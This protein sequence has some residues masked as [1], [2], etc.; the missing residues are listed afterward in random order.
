MFWTIHCVASHFPYM[1]VLSCEGHVLTFA[2]VMQTKNYVELHPILDPGSVQICSLQWYCNKAQSSGS[3]HELK[4]IGVMRCIHRHWSFSHFNLWLLR[5]DLIVHT[6]SL[7]VMFDPRT[8]EAS[9]NLLLWCPSKRALDEDYMGANQS[10][11]VGKQLLGS[12]RV[13]FL[14][15]R[16]QH[17]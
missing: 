12:S 1:I 7:N 17:S 15:V 11:F 13:W 14:Q 3:L 6:C 2:E 4:L 16:S 8:P 10:Q 9:S 5:Q